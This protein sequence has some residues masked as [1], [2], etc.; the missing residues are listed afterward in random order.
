MTNSFSRG[1]KSSQPADD[2]LNKEIHRIMA[3]K[4]AATSALVLGGIFVLLG[5][6]GFV[7]NPMIGRQ[8][9]IVTDSIQDIAHICLGLMLVISGFTGESSATFGLYAVGVISV[10]FGAAGL[11]QLGSYSVGYLGDTGMQ[12]SAAGCWFHI[13][14]ALVLLVCGKMNTTSKQLFH[15]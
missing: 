15:E 3:T 14:L 7:T 13:A 4:V 6:L 10:C 2:V 9:F 8:A 5:T 11:Y 1:L 12:L